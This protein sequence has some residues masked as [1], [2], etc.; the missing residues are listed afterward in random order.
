LTL[1]VPGCHS[2]IGY[3]R[4]VPGQGIEP[5]SPRSERG[6]LPVRRSRTVPLRSAPV[7]RE[8]D[9]KAFGQ[10]ALGSCRASY[11]HATRLPFDPG[12]SAAKRARP[13]DDVVV[14][15][16]WSRSLMHRCEMCRQKHTL[17]P[18]RNSSTGRKSGLSLSGG[19]S[20]RSRLV[21]AEHHLVSL[22]VVAS[23][24]TKA[25]RLGRPRLALLCG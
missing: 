15:G 20:S 14:E 11:V 6:V 12:S 21:Q 24:T 19:A 4:T 10:T 1:A 22:V 13:R 18:K 7:R 9:A 5:R 3:L 17:M 8:L 2:A 23:K 16:L 25:T